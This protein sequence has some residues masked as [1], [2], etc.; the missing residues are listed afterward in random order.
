MVAMELVKEG[1][2]ARPDPDLTKRLVAEAGKRGW[3][4][5]PAACVAT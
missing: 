3:C 5:W 2:A 4:C 1:D